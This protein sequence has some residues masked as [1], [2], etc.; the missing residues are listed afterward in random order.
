M[1]FLIEQNRKK[2]YFIM[3]LSKVAQTPLK[4]RRKKTNNDVVIVVV[5]HRDK[6]PFIFSMKFPL[7]FQLIKII[8]LFLY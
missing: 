1:I 7:N 2:K 4:K 5:K 6:I 3:Q 8:D